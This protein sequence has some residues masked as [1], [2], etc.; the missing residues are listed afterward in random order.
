MN[1]A[2]TAYITVLST[3][4]ISSITV[5]E[6][7]TLTEEYVRLIVENGC[8]D[9]KD[10]CSVL[11]TSLAWSKEL[12]QACSA[13]TDVNL[14][15][16][17]KAAE[18]LCSLGLWLG[19]YGHLARSVSLDVDEDSIDA[20]VAASTAA[21][22]LP[23]CFRLAQQSATPFTL[24][25]FEC[26]FYH[27]PSML[28]QL[29]AGSL[30]R[31]VFNIGG[32]YGIEG[33]LT[34][35]SHTKALASLTNLRHLV[36]HIDMPDGFEWPVAYLQSVEA[37]TQLTYLE[38]NE[39]AAEDAPM[40]L[41]RLPSSLLHLYI[42][43][44]DPDDPMELVV[45][46]LDHLSKLTRLDFDQPMDAASKLPP[47]LLALGSDASWG[48][49]AAL[50]SL[51]KLEHVTIYAAEDV[52]AAALT[53][54]NRLTSLTDISLGCFGR[55]CIR[56]TAP[57]WPQL[58]SLKHLY[59]A[60]CGLLDGGSPFTA[61]LQA[62]L[63]AAT[64]LTRLMISGSGSNEY[65]SDAADMVALYQ[66][67]AG[68]GKLQELSLA[69]IATP[70]S[71]LPLAR[72]TQL[73]MLL[74]ESCDIPDMAATAI[75][76]SLRQLRSLALVDE[77]RLTDACMPALGLLTSLTS[78]SLG[79]L[80]RTGVTVEGVMQL[81]SLRGLKELDVFPLVVPEPLAAMLPLLKG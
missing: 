23:L 61:G 18:Q 68:L 3:G 53:T 49:I 40:F 64:G 25:S 2:W 44:A 17:E 1:S 16:G 59:L 35:P 55:T 72:A 46:D 75:G 51:R 70:Q 74:I 13:C 31:L 7:C 29:P 73:T 79:G 38:L 12:E 11:Q 34:S 77:K 45:M 81:S 9:A 10:I 57:L 52:A 50:S 15:L 67:I 37:L 4:T 47:S 19:R 65:R 39:A 71:A 5:E 58:R 32:P 54:L 69:R 8:L 6:R 28:Y 21:N 27:S 41:P 22:M 14:V 36:L 80:G 43:F 24:Q 78:L 30:T 63:A 60:D 20:S 56:A 42:R 62:D 33:D 48:S 66:V 76:C 26:F